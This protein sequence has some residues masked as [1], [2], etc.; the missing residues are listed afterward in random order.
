LK[1]R[2]PA[3]VKNEIPGGLYHYTNAPAKPYRVLLN[4]KAVKGELKNGYL[5]IT[6]TWKTG[7][8][9]ELQ[10]PMQIRTVEADQQ[11]KNDLGKFAVEYGPLVYCMEEADNPAWLSPT[12]F[13]KSS[14]IKWRPDLLGGINVISE[15]TGKGECILIP[16]YI[17]SNRGVGKMKVWF[18]SK[19]K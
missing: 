5:E 14:V 15:K 3:W 18:D 8:R 12:L 17:W 7:D 2:I 11:V 19:G 4:G 13:P 16:Y 9:I 6:R 10:F 1:I